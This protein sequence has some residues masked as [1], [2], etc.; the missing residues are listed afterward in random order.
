MKC[1]LVLLAVAAIATVF[2]WIKAA[3]AESPASCAYFSWIDVRD[4]KSNV[5]LKF[6]VVWDV[7]ALSRFS[8]GSEA[9]IVVEHSDS[10]QTVF[11]TGR[12][13]EEGLPLGVSSDGYE[14]A[15]IKVEAQSGGIATRGPRDIVRVSLRKLP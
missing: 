12:Y 10:T 3:E 2:W 6:K 7:E 4:E 8:K 1:W 13:L 15:E 11:L 5:Q 9:A 14:P